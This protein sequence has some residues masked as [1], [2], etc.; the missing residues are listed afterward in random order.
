VQAR[1]PLA[2]ETLQVQG[3]DAAACTQAPK[4]EDGVAD[5]ATVQFN[6][7]DTKK[8]AKSVLEIVTEYES[9]Q[10]AKAS[11]ANRAKDEKTAQKCDSIGFIPAG[12]T[13]AVANTVHEPQKLPAVGDESF[14]ER[15][16]ASSGG[17]SS[18]IAVV[19]AGDAIVQINTFDGLTSPSVVKAGARDLGTIAKHAVARLPHSVSIAPPPEPRALAVDAATSGC[20]QTGLKSSTSSKKATITFENTTDQQVHVSWIDFDGATRPYGDVAADSTH[21]QETFVGHVWQVTDETEQCV[22]ITTVSKPNV[23]VKIKG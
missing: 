9:V 20:A 6:R 19:R 11:F 23:V 16:T 21:V 4:P 1:A 17:E 10:A 3:V 22:Q 7:V 15:L 2:Y 18:L 14:A 13:T 12:Q 8:G 5:A